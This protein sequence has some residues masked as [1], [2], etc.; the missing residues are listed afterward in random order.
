MYLVKVSNDVLKLTGQG[1]EWLVSEQGDL[2][3]KFW[4][5]AMVGDNDNTHVA[6]ASDDVTKKAA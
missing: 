3:A 5:G 4:N 6:Q 1:E 2:L